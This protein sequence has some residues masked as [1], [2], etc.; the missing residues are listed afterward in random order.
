[1]QVLSR[2][3]G[4]F[5]LIYHLKGT[6]GFLNQ[7]VVLLPIRSNGGYF[8]FQILLVSAKIKLL[9]SSNNLPLMGLL[10]AQLPCI[11]QI[12]HL[13][14]CFLSFFLF[15][16]LKVGRRIVILHYSSSSSLSLSLSIVY[17]L[18]F[19]VNLLLFT[20]ILTSSR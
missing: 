19:S 3:C 14:P 1:M 13:F 16:V 2:L 15:Y 6:H 7:V 10:L 11:P 20:C 8:C 9:M 18:L 17:S 12:M 4:F 5:T